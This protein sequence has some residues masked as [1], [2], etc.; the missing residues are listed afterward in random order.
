M[1]FG[2]EIRLWLNDRGKCVSI[3]DYYCY[4]F[5]STY[6]LKPSR[7]IVRYGLDAPTFAN[8][9]LH[10]CHHAKTPSG[11]RWSCGQEMSGNF[12]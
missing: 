3:T 11:G 4:Y 8:R 2:I 12:A 5:F 6:A 10:M 7:L 1:L 9:R